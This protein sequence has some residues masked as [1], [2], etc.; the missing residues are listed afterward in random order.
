MVDRDGSQCC[1][2]CYVVCSV[3]PVLVCL[4]FHGL[5]TGA[6]MP[7]P[8]HGQPPPLRAHTRGG[9]KPASVWWW[10]HGQCWESD[11]CYG[12]ALMLQKRDQ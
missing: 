3:G 4:A 8:L 5:F 7:R 1:C 2:G 12:V 6:K 10:D 9:G 11:V